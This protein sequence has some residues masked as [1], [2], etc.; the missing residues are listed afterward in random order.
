MEIYWPHHVLRITAD[1]N[2]AEYA[3]RDVEAVLKG[4]SRL[5]LNLEP[6]RPFLA[7]KHQALS[8]L[9]EVFKPQ[10]IAFVERMAGVIV[11][12][13]TKSSVSL[14]SHFGT[15]AHSFSSSSGES[16][17]PQPQM[18]GG[19]YCQCCNSRAQAPE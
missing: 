10:D 1:K 7:K 17:A 13:T 14:V 11:Q 18:A 9:N 5:Q 3:A 8:N 2:S 4:T 6:W 12:M 19:A 16:T 15:L